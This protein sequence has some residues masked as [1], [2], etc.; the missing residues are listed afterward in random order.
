MAC[1]LFRADYRPADVVKSDKLFQLVTFERFDR[2]VAAA[3]RC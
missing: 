3:A 1:E 2:F